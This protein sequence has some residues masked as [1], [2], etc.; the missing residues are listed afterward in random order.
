MWSIFDEM[1]VF[2]AFC[3]HG[4]TLVITDMVHSG[5]QLVIIDTHIYNANE[6]TEPSILLLVLRNY[7]IPLDLILV[8]VQNPPQR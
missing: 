6:I 7:S 2:M 5:E 1:G 4:F 3:H 8:S